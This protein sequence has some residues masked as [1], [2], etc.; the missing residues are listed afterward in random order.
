M[1]LGSFGHSLPD[2]LQEIAKE[3]EEKR[4]RHIRRAV[5][6][7]ERLKSCPPCLGK[8]KYAASCVNI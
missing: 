8:H 2:I 5:A 6:K 7:Q 1:L 3:D 4:K